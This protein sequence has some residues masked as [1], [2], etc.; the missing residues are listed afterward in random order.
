MFENHEDI[1]KKLPE[2]ALGVLDEA[3][4]QNVTSHLEGCQDCMKEFLAHQAVADQ[5][6]L[7]APEATPSDWVKDGIMRR[8]LKDVIA[9]EKRRRGWWDRLNLNLGRLHPAASY[10]AVI[11]MLI[12]IAG[13][14]LLWR[15]LAQQS[16]EQ[17]LPFQTISLSS[18]DRMPEAFGV[19][20]ISENG[21]EGT[22]VAESLAQLSPEQQYQLWLIMGDERTSGGV[23][24]ATEEGYA[25]LNIS[26]PI[27]LEN[28]SAFG[29]TIEPAGGSARPTGEKVLGGEL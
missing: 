10:G 7:A 18:T 11:L 4:A 22:L 13:N 27:S 15:E 3:E 1:Q 24:S 2:Y 8:A 9:V 19:I 26:A 5:L 29:I 28:Y 12:S 21:K 14:V 25:T 6:G 17:S 23:F 20:L 16:V